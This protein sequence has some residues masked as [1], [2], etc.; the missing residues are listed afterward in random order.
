[1]DVNGKEMDN[2]YKFLKRQSPLF[3]PA[4][5][6][7]SHIKQHYSKFLCNKYGEVKH[8]YEPSV[9]IAIIE[10]DIRKLL[11]EEFFEETF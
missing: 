2:L 8:Y 9:E 10:A 11:D 4:Y 5:G 7:A 3:T 6:K 1:M